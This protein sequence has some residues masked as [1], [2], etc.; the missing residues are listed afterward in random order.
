MRTQTIGSGSLT[1]T[2]LAYGCWRLAGTKNSSEVNEEHRSAGKKAVLAAYDAGYRLFDHAD[3]YTDGAAEE[4]F[5]QVLRENS[6]LRKDILIATKC[7][8]RRAGDP[9]PA[10]PHRYDFSA[11]YILIACD[12]SLRRL[13]IETI[14][15]YQ[16]HRLDLLMNPHEVAGAFEKLLRQGKARFFGVSNFTTS[17]LSALQAALPFELV[18]H[19]QEIHLGRLNCFYDGTLDQC[20]Q[21]KITPLAWSPL[22]GGIFGS[23]STVPAAHPHKAVLDAVLTTLDKIA[24]ALGVSRTVVALSWIKTHPANIIPMVGSCN[25]QRIREAAAAAALD[26]SREQWYELLVAARGKRLD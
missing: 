11:E 26:L 4:I 17:A 25:P 20:L 19:Q 5:G 13:N 2:R 21:K 6:S 3:I 14:D 24:A 18:A 23:G 1:S 12:R 9:H 22:F 7:G 15:L 10:S 8:I 16:L